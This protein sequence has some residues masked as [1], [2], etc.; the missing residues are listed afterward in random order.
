MRQYNTDLEGPLV[1]NDNAFELA[2]HFIPNGEKLFGNLSKYDDVLAD[3]FKRPG[4]RAGNTL[5]FMVPFLKAYG[6]SD[7]DIVDFS[8]ERIIIIPGAKDT[9]ECVNR[10]M[11]S[12]IVSTSYLPFVYAVC[13]RMG[14]PF[15]N[16]YSTIMSIEEYHLTRGDE[17]RLKELAEEIGNME[18]IEIPE[19]ACRIDDFQNPHR[20]NIC[21]LDGIIYGEFDK[22]KIGRDAHNIS[23]VGGPEKA[24][25]IR[26]SLKRTGNNVSEVMYVGDSITDVQAFQLVKGAGGLAVSFNG[27]PYAIREAEVAVLSEHTVPSEVIAHVFNRHGREGVMGL[28]ESGF[29]NSWKFI[30][31]EPSLLNRVDHL[32]ES[33]LKEPKVCLITDENRENLAEE[34]SEFRKKVRTEMVGAL[35]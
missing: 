29:A 8:R 18:M 13:K 16:A 19:G 30:D 34:S 2:E 3:I 15:G 17:K 28:L 9:V 1:S 31:D 25:S 27:N 33:G 10:M 21:R 12:F 11:P 6:V 7:K 26:K 35:G 22:M 23:V 4:Y 32:Y 5:K 24:E 14:F 20:E